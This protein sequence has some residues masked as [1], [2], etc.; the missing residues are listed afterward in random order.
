MNES[1]QKHRV[2]LHID[3]NAFYCS[4]H[5][6][7]EPEKYGG[8]PTVVAGS[9]EQRRGVIVTASYVARK[10]GIRAGMLVHQAKRLEPELIV[11]KPNFDLYR[12]FSKEF[13]QIAYQY[14]PLMEPA[15]IDECYL[16]ITGSKQF[17]HP[18]EIAKEIQAKIND[19][20]NL[21]CSIGIGPNKLLAKM[22]SDM[23]KPLGITVLR[24]R[25]FPRLFWEKPTNSLFGIGGKLANKLDS[26]GIKTIGE[27][28]KADEGL[29]AKELGI[30][31]KQ[32]KEKANGID[33]SLVNSEAEKNKSIGH[34]TTLPQDII[35]KGE[36][37]SI[38]LN[39]ADQV[40]RRLRK[41]KMLAKTIQITIRYSDRM[42]ITRSITIDQPTENMN[43]IYHAACDLFNKYWSK[44]PVRLLGI[45]L[46]NLTEKEEAGIQLDIFSYQNHTKK[47]ELNKAVDMLRDKYGENMI[48]P[49]GMVVNKSVKSDEK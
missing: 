25:D 9:E 34:T 5:E 22:A 7:V 1:E 44:K 10:K 26:I 3:M 37:N 16:D 23:K 31:G 11:I 32:L 45:T 19:Q 30:L 42:T 38:F 36:A 4:V 15:S 48:I 6:A 2:I 24:I 49:A 39:L 17:G 41:Q 13:L 27:L 29:L 20:L 33:Y 46:Q 18:I 21:P 28:A 40:A 47:E 12:R 43:D 14:S 35:E 8:K